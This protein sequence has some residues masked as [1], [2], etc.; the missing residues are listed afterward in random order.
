[1]NGPRVLFSS[2]LVQRKA[3][4]LSLLTMIRARHAMCSGAGGANDRP[5]GSKCGVNRPDQINE[6]E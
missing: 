5:H 1:M 3:L 2:Q 4:L 6:E